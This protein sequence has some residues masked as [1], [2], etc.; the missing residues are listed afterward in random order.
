MVKNNPVSSLKSRAVR[1][2]HFHF[3]LVL[4]FSIQTIVYHASQV[5]TPELLM[6]RWFA[7][8]GLLVVAT[9]LWY[10]A[11]NKVTGIGGFQAIIYALII[12][13]IAFAAF[14]VYTQRGYASKSVVLFVIPIFVAAVLARRSA[15]FATALLSIAAYT[16]TAITYFVKNFNEGY[17]AELYGEIGFYSALY[18][19]LAALLW[20]LVRKQKE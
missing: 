5:I 15:L 8:A 16:T 19:L 3:A 20:T 1:V 2:A 12:A 18:L 13:D 17:M 7:T 10:F 11:K 4:L 6:K 14:N 9:I